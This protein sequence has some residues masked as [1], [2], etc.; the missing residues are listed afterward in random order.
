MIYRVF[1]LLASLAMTV[2]Y[3]LAPNGAW[4]YRPETMKLMFFHVPPA[5]L[6]SLFFLWG[7][8]QGVLYLVKRN[9]KNDF[10]GLAS[11]EVG[12]LLC[13]LATVTGSFFAYAQWD[14]FWTWDPRQTN[15]FLQLMVYM[16]Y[17]AVRSSMN[18]EELKARVSAV[19]SIFAFVT[20]PFL[21]W[22]LPRVMSGFSQHDQ[23]NSVVVKGQMDATYKILFYSSALVILLVSAW[24]CRL[25]EQVHSLSAMA[26]NP[27]DKSSDV[28]DAGP[29]VVRP[30]RTGDA[31]SPADSD[32]A[33]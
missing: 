16:A 3:V 29:R 28:S 1:L 12:T 23:A 8:V 24:V 11:I 4:T 18:G 14:S 10:Q 19:Y 22:V 13:V 31:H 2:A 17:F 9:P 20:V 32:S 7:A 30:V 21:V 33:V 6:C 5:M 26:G 27:Y 15:I 25:R